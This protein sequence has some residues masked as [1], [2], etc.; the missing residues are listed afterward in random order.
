MLA[1]WAT[2][3]GKIDSN[4]PSIR[5]HGPQYNALSS[6]TRRRCHWQ[7]SA[8]MWWLRSTARR[9]EVASIHGAWRKVGSHRSTVRKGEG[10]FNLVGALRGHNEQQVLFICLVYCFFLPDIWYTGCR[11]TSVRRWRTWEMLTHVAVR[12]LMYLR[13]SSSSQHIFSVMVNEAWFCVRH[14]ACCP[15]WPSCSLTVLTTW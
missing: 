1:R 13:M 4:C 9:S 7:W 12:R 10:G 15:Q 6:H 8:A 14:S 2:R 3:G 11:C 5:N